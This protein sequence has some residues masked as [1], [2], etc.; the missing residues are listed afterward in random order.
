MVKWS[1]VLITT[2]FGFVFGIACLFITNAAG[3][4]FWPLGISWVL[5]HTLMGFTIG[6][7]PWKMHWAAHGTVWGV[8]FAIP[9]AIS[10]VGLISP[11]QTFIIIVVW[12]FLIELI[13]TK[14]FKRPQ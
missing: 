1:R 4:P 9:T 6:I 7:S 10:V 11:L 13:A 12:G 5:H 3:V 8:L 2:V 14:A